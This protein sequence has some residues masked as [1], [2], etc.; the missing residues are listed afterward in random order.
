MVPLRF[1][2]WLLLIFGRPESADRIEEGSGHHAAL[3]QYCAS[4]LPEVR[5]GDVERWKAAPDRIE[6]PAPRLQ[7]RSLPRG[8]TRQGHGWPRADVGD[9]ASEAPG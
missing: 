3:R 9:A 4:G 1:G 7:V 6:V 8:S 5:G 2:N